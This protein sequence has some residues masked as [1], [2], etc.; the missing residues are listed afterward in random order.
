MVSFRGEGMPM[1][2]LRQE[3]GL[4]MFFLFVSNLPVID[5]FLIRGPFRMETTF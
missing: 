5:G 2:Q 3:E 4:Q 1:D